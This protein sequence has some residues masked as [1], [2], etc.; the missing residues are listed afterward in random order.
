MWHWQA[1]LLGRE[2][3][4]GL[5][6]PYASGVAEGWPASGVQ[7]TRLQLLWMDALSQT[8]SLC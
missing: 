1:L 6:S 8:N 7:C 5:I 4:G 2:P 3:P